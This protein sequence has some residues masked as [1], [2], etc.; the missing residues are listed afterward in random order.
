[1]N[2]RK[3]IA[4]NNQEAI[5]VVKA[6]MGP[7]AVILRTRTIH[8]AEGSVPGKGKVEV[9][10]AIDYAV[11]DETEGKENPQEPKWTPERWK[12]L[13]AEIREIKAYL[14]ALEAGSVLKPEIYYNLSLRNRYNFFRDFGLNADVIERLMPEKA[15]H[16][17]CHAISD[18]EHLKKCLLDLLSR[19]KVNGEDRDSGGRRILS[20]IGPTGVGKTTTLAKLA[21]MKAVEERKR[22]ALVTVD[23]FRIAAV[24]QLETYARIMSVPLEVAGSSQ[25]L[26]NAL[27]KHENCDLVL[28]DTAGRSPNNRKEIN[29]IHDVFHIPERVHHYLVLSATTQ[30]SH[31]VNAE[32]R[33]GV[34]PFKSYIFTKLDEVD[35]AS[36]MVNFL[37]SRSKPVSYFTTGQQVP[38]DIEP[39]S[40]K[41][42]A[43]MILG[44]KKAMTANSEHEVN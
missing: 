41:R 5:K 21:A 13:D 39:A 29:E 3:F 23:T 8:P 2:I 33:F 1:M 24:A 12:N 11:T 26:H 37:F 14:R 38:E 19:V 42:L 30:Y 9:T 43:A 25:E 6:E 22:V 40:R 18:R 15:S 16:E 31:L 10:A 20:F 28:I 35:D 27:K 36:P 17:G 44:R 32:S 34:L 7:D 4:S